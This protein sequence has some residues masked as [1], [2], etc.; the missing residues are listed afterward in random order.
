MCKLQYK[1]RLAVRG[2]LCCHIDSHYQ[3]I[4]PTERAEH[5]M[6][7]RVGEMPALGETEADHKFEPSLHN[8][9]I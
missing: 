9:A 8:L 4:K 6:K 7:E 5:R 1:A 2:Y 3:Q